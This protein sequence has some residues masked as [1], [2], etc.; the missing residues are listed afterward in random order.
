MN[1]YQYG[2]LLDPYDGVQHTASYNDNLRHKTIN[3]II[4]QIVFPLSIYLFIYLFIYSLCFV[5]RLYVY[6][7]LVIRSSFLVKFVNGV[8]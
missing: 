1:A 4:T 6:G 7:F 8:E 2:C 3:T 5:L